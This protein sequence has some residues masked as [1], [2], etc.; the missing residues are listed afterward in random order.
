MKI[1]CLFYD[2]AGGIN[3][4]NSLI[5]E[6]VKFWV[7]NCSP[8]SQVIQFSSADSSVSVH[9]EVI[10]KEQPDVIITQDVFPNI[11]QAIHNSNAK[12]KL[13]FLVSDFDNEEILYSS[14]QFLKLYRGEKDFDFFHEFHMPFNTLNWPI[15]KSWG[16]RRNFCFVGRFHPDKVSPEVINM[17]EVYGEMNDTMLCKYARD[18]HTYKGNLPRGDVSIVLNNYK[19]HILHTATDCF[20]LISAEAM[21]SGTIPIIIPQP[22]Y[23]LYPWLNWM[24]ESFGIKYDNFLDFYRDADRL[25]KEDFTNKAKK[26]SYWIKAFHNQPNFASHLDRVLKE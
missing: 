19:Y 16:D 7:E 11:L 26:E 15:L 3:I 14:I 22:Q 9:E 12:K 8:E 18:K 5:Y 4:V 17:S 13:S 24:P 1:L 21:M 20:S 10:V 25:R 23:H 6:G 2:S